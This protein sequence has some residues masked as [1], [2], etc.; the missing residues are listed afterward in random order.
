MNEAAFEET[1]SLEAS[2]A[3]TST[4]T[5]RIEMDG[6]RHIAESAA[7]ARAFF[8]VSSDNDDASYSKI[9]VS[10]KRTPKQKSMRDDDSAS[11]VN[12][13]VPPGQNPP[14]RQ[15]SA[16]PIRSVTTQSKKRSHEASVSTSTVEETQN[17]DDAI[18]V[19]AAKRIRLLETATKAASF[20]SSPVKTAFGY[21]SAAVS[22]LAFGKT[23]D[24]IAE[25]QEEQPPPISEEEK[26]RI[27]IAAFDGSEAN[28]IDLYKTLPWTIG[29]TFLLEYVIPSIGYT[30]WIV[31]EFALHGS[32][33]QLP[34]MPVMRLLDT[35][36]YETID[37]VSNP[38]NVW[39]RERQFR[40]YILT[41]SINNVDPRKAM[42]NALDK[43]NFASV[44]LA[45]SLIL[46]KIALS[47]PDIEKLFAQLV[48]EEWSGDNYDQVEE[49]PDYW[50]CLGLGDHDFFKLR[51]LLHIALSM[52]NE[53]PTSHAREELEFFVM[54]KYW[55][56]AREDMYASVT[57]YYFRADNPRRLTREGFTFFKA[58]ILSLAGD[59]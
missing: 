47:K 26:L 53:V 50:K 11:D 42:T 15:E 23:T 45:I 8:N 43:E 28:A 25:Q 59:S 22:M 57:N 55:Q 37:S 34:L 44:G 49:N 4:V 24:P 32:L 33:K 52:L 58:R 7:E 19:P 36:G 39:V 9:G 2:V 12:E 41:E 27:A 40:S 48:Q 3:A 21:A 14:T 10:T 16:V 1:T 54:Q 56:V 5:N 6:S 46:Q 38:T 51:C 17:D 29:N 30:T 35:L 18:V 13:F 20:M 31:K